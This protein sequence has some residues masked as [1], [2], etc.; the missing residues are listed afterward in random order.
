MSI[1]HSH[2]E[3]VNKCGYST[4]FLS[5]K[6]PT[7]V[8]WLFSLLQLTIIQP[9]VTFFGSLFFYFLF[10]FAPVPSFPP[11]HFLLFFPPLL[12]PSILYLF[13]SFQLQEQKRNI[14]RCFFFFPNPLSFHQ[15]SR[16]VIYFL[17]I[18]S[19]CHR[20]VNRDITRGK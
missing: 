19:C 3:A 4:G 7:S 13:L 5:R 17:K 11:P 12:L 2:I 18:T 8:A 14:L 16:N 20:V 1:L 15:S 10:F 9:N 6:F